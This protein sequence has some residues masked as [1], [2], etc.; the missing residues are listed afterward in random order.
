[1]ARKAKATHSEVT[2]EVTGSGEF[3]IDML[4]YD[5]CVPATGTDASSIEREGHRV[6]KLRRFYPVGGRATPE[7][8]RWLSWGWRVSKIYDPVLE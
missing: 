2:F 1:M 3:P 7:D 4:R 5:V 8:A 6:V